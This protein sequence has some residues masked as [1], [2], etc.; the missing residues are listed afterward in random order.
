M[1]AEYVDSSDELVHQYC[2]NFDLRVLPAKQYD[3][4]YVK[5]N[6]FSMEGLKSGKDTLPYDGI[7]DGKLF[8]QEARYIQQ[9]IDLVKQKGENAP[10]VLALDNMSIED[11]LKKGG[12]PKD[13]IDLYTYTNAT[14]STT[15]PSKM[16]ALYMV[17]TNARASAFSE[18]T[19]EGR[20]L[21]GNDKLPKT[22]AKKL[23]S[24]IKYNR[25]LKRL[26]FNDK[27]ITAIV[28][29]NGVNESIKALKCVIAIPASVLKNIDIE[30]GFSS[31]K[32]YCI[33]NQ[34]YGHVMKVAMQYQKRFWDQKQSIGQRV[35]T[36]TRLRRVYHFSIDQPGPRG[37]LLTFTSG[38]DAKKLGRLSEERRMRVAQ[39]T[40]ENIWPE[41]VSYTHLTLPT[42]Y[43]V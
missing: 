39:E 36:D 3:G 4:V 26:K 2:K 27:G 33:Q 38:E 37:I 14:E 24:K 6:R 25:A 42:I 20:I 31:D 11:M 17:L 9:W 13:I 22:F 8:G 43:S 10:E 28:N 1:G 15:V 7:L 41:S 29:K 16:S 12:A 19:V 18:D 35:F 34:D 23:G 21:G 30:P 40:C 5:G 32:T